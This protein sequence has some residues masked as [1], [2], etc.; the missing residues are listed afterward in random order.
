MRYGAKTMDE[1][2]KILISNLEKDARMSLKKLAQE[3]GLKTSTE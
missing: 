3:M 1:M 2:D